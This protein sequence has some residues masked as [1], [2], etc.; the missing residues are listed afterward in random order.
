MKFFTG[1]RTATIKHVTLPTSFWSF[2]T[3]TRGLF[4]EGPEKFLHLESRSKITNLYMITEL[5]YSH[6]LNMNRGSP[7]VRSFRR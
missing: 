1:D 6:I 5:L 7:H 4:L 2:L 3:D